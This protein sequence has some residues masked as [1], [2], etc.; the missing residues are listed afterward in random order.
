MEVQGNILKTLLIVAVVYTLALG[1]PV[2][3]QTSSSIVADACAA[4]RDTRKIVA[5]Y[6]PTVTPL[7]ENT[8]DE[9][10]AA[11]YLWEYLTE[12][13][14]TGAVCEAVRKCLNHSDSY[15]KTC[16][17]AAAAMELHDTINKIIAKP[18]AKTDAQ[19]LP[20]NCSCTSTDEVEV[21]G[22]LCYAS[23]YTLKILANIDDYWKVCN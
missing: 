20:T 7:T 17:L 9:S 13:N 14:F 21:E 10:R 1:A 11:E 2:K 18:G 3:R 23:K 16:K 19:P 5:K 8:Y 15:R 6:C 22:P 4:A 12:I